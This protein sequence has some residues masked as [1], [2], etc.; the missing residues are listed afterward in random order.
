M[1]KIQTDENILCYESKDE[2]G[3]EYHFMWKIKEHNCP[4]GGAPKIWH[5]LFDTTDLDDFVEKLY[6]A[7][8]KADAWYE[9]NKDKENYAK[10]LKEMIKEAKLS[11]EK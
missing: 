7:K 9:E 10:A 3:A 8:A 6:A 5:H 11:E 2:N 4:K 1:S